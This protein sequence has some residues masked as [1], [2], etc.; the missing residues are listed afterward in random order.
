MLILARKICE[1]IVISDEIIVTILAVKGN[2][3]RLGIDAPIEIPVHRYEI[4]QRIQA[5]KQLTG[6]GE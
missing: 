3:V 6:E 1:K 5:E 2:Q 4:F